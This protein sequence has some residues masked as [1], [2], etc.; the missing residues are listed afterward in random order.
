MNT[1]QNN[2][3]DIQV[4]THYLAAE[5]EPNESKYVFA[6]TIT[7]EN[8]GDK[9]AKLMTRHWIIRDFNGKVQEVHGDGIVGNQPYLRPGEGFQYTSGAVIETAAGTMEGSYGMRDDDGEEFK[10]PIPPFTLAATRILH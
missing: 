6:Y 3:I 2:N 7:I 9:P 8:R 5:S 1:D 10:A 4:E